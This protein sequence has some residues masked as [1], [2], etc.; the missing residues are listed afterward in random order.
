MTTPEDPAL[1]DICFPRDSELTVNY[2]SDATTCSTVPTANREHLALSIDAETIMKY[3][4]FIPFIFLS[5]DLASLVQQ[6][7]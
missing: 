3:C 4:Y 6:H 1:L 5:T 2:Q 7:D